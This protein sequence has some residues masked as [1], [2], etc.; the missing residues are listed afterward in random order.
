M[1]L[2]LRRPLSSLSRIR[3]STILEREL[4]DS[5]KATSVPPIGQ[6][7]PFGKI[8]ED[9]GPPQGLVGGAGR[10][11]WCGFDGLPGGSRFASGCRTRQQSRDATVA[12]AA[13]HTR[14]MA[15]EL[16][17][18][19]CD[20]IPAIREHRARRRRPLRTRLAG[21]DRAHSLT[22]SNVSTVVPSERIHCGCWFRH[23]SAHLHP[24]AIASSIRA[25]PRSPDGISPRSAV[26][27][28]PGSIAE[29]DEGKRAANRACP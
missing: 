19:I 5:G 3:A 17:H 20:L 14:H 25:L 7:V 27:R 23:S 6:T 28:R 15:A 24:E 1:L 4:T 16:V 9:T 13:I 22:D 11:H 18:G 12:A 2:A 26:N 29:I 21:P 10:T 8:T